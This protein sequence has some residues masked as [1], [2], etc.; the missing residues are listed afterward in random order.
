MTD[1][2]G[3]ALALPFSPYRTSA[4][5]FG[6]WVS[7]RRPGKTR[8][9]GVQPG[10]ACYESICMLNTESGTPPPIPTGPGFAGDRQ[11]TI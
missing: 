4:T 11:E 6:V 1:P 10:A 7:W 9:S 3:N 2:Q 5:Y 8:A